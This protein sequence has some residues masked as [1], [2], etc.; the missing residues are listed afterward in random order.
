M[1]LTVRN[2]NNESFSISVVHKFG[3]RD[4]LVWSVLSNVR[5]IEY[6]F[7]NKGII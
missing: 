1:E 5:D 3:A 4:P 2:K 7:F 6:V